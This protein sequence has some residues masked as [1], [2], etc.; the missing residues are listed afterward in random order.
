MVLPEKLL[1]VF[2]QNAA[3]YNQAAST[4]EQLALAQFMADG[5]LERQIRRLRKLYCE[6]KLLLFDA[7]KNMWILRELNQDPIRFSM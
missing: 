4:I 1:A 2:Q 3:L 5:C 7:V 6:K